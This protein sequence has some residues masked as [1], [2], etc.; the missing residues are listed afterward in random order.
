MTSEYIDIVFDGPP[1]PAAGR[2]IEV[3]DAT[4]AS[5]TFGE[6]IERPDGYWA[7]RFTPTGINPEFIKA[8]Q[9]EVS[10]YGNS[11]INAALI[12]QRLDA[13]LQSIGDTRDP[14]IDP[15]KVRELRDKWRKEGDI[16]LK[17]AQENYS[18]GKPAKAF[19]AKSDT[20]DDC[21]DELDTLLQSVEEEHTAGAI[22]DEFIMESP[23]LNYATLRRY[24]NAHPDLALR[25]VDLY[26]VAALADARGAARFP[27][28]DPADAERHESAPTEP[29]EETL[30]VTGMNNTGD[31][32]SVYLYLSNGETAILDLE[33]WGIATKLSP[34]Q[35]NP[36]PMVLYCPN[37]NAQHVD[38]PGLFGDS[39]TN[40]PH[41]SHMCDECGCIWRPADVPTE[42]VETIKTRGKRD[43]WPPTDTNSTKSINPLDIDKSQTIANIL[44]LFA[45]YGSG[46]YEPTEDEKDI[47]HT[48]LPEALDALLQAAYSRTRT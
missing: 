2:F 27:D 10:E 46:D 43:T 19:G 8:L 24:I 1:R 9:D 23:P 28:E 47:I 45:R 3:E 4:G 12:W 7:L 35:P 30:A 37:C 40:P 26:H 25:L 18:M 14:T 20:L 36:V 17:Q 34:E 6:W 29:T 38:G 13:L 21:A 16:A 42:G 11:K 39:W 41:R 32:T 22:L 5:I 48:A 44:D 15:E 33:E 31:C